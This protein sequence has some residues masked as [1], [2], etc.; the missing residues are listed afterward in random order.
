MMASL[1]RLTS[2][3]SSRIST[4]FGA[5]H[6]TISTRRSSAA[7]CVGDQALTLVRFG[8]A[9]ARSIDRHLLVLESERSPCHKPLAH[10]IFSQPSEIN[11]P[12]L[13]SLL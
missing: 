9:V 13:F 4:F 5:K 10:N 8:V 6:C 11:V 1:P 7:T 3:R 2:K 12:F